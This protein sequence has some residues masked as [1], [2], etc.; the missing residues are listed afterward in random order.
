MM[1]EFDMFAK[2]LADLINNKENIII[3]ES[4]L[5][6]QGMSTLSMR[7]AYYIKSKNNKKVEE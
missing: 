6:R 1:N 2:K 7:V 5:T 3:K 4:G